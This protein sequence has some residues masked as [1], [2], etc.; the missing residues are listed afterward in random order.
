MTHPQTLVARDFL[1]HAPVTTTEKYY[2]HL[3]DMQPFDP[4]EAIAEYSEKLSNNFPS[5]K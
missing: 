5:V 2:A 4:H 1:G 3:I